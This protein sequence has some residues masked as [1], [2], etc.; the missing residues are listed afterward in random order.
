M[1]TGCFCCAQINRTV[2]PVQFSM[3]IPDPAAWHAAPKEISS[4]NAAVMREVATILM[5]GVLCRDEWLVILMLC[6]MHGSQYLCAFV[7]IVASSQPSRSDSYRVA[8]RPEL[9]YVSRRALARKSHVSWYYGAHKPSLG[10]KTRALATLYTRVLPL[11][12][13]YPLQPPP[14]APYAAPGTPFS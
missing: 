6:N 11:T 1:V 12:Q 9:T 5:W 2:S 14:A 10:R 13:P 4:R 7:T 8:T 3:V